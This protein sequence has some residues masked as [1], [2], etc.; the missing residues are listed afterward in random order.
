MDHQNLTPS[1]AVVKQTIMDVIQSGS[2]YDVES[3]N[4]LYSDNLQIVRVASDGQTR[5][6]GK[7]DVLGFFRSMR[8]KNA[9]PLSTEAH[10]NHIE[11]GDDFAH[12]VV[13]RSM[14]LFGKPEKS[15]YS[16]CLTRKESGWKV[17]KET[18]VSFV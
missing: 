9:E 8:S 2:V 7:S 3:L 16:L 5:V 13:T 14:K 17:V 10:F 6:L 4:L 11:V 1:E 15:V 18:V 12:A